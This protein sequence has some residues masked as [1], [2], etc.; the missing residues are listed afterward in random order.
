MKAR[1]LEPST[2]ATQY[3]IFGILQAPAGSIAIILPQSTS[4][5]ALQFDA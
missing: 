2:L 4:P 1:P 5:S 3:R